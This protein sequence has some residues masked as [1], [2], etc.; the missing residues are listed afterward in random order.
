VHVG[1]ESGIPEW[2]LANRMAK[3]RENAGLTRWEIACLLE[4]TGGTVGYWERGSVDL[5]MRP[6]FGG[7]AGHCRVR[8]HVS[9]DHGSIA[10]GGLAPAVLSVII[11]PEA[12]TA[13][14]GTR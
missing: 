7:P 11:G 6:S 1:P 13:R 2:G 14:T 10:P 5:A 8:A 3:A 12:A 4:V 9:E